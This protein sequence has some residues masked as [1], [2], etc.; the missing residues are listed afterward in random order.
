MVCFQPPSLLI[1]KVWVP[2]T[3]ICACPFHC[4]VHLRVDRRLWSCRLISVQPLIGS[5]IRIFS[6]GSALWVLE[7][8]CYLYWHSFCQTDHRKVMVDG[9]WSKLV[10]VVSVV[11]QGSILGSLLFLLHT[12]ELFSIQEN[13]LI[14]YADDYF[15]GCCAI[16]R[17]QS[18]SS[19]VPDQWPWQG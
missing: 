4:K 13:K 17:R 7:C 9:C 18:Y 3:Y 14:G 6:I 16:H 1:G 11:P 12:S 8:L 19:R 15:D 2:V 5:T 10:H